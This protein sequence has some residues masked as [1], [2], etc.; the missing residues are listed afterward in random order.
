MDLSSVDLDA[1]IQF[2]NTPSHTH[3]HT[4]TH[5]QYAVEKC[6]VDKYMSNRNAAT[7]ISVFIK[8]LNQGWR[9]V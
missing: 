6:M 5:L 7:I 9:N 4:H 2:T 3:A 8:P 1:N